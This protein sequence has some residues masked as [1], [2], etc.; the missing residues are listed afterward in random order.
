MIKLRNVVLSLAAGF[1]ATGALAQDGH[2]VQDSETTTVAHEMFGGDAVKLDFLAFD[3]DT[4]STMFEPKAKLIFGGSATIDPGTEFSVT[5]TL[6]NAT[7]A[8]SVSYRDFMWGSWSPLA[9]TDDTDTTDVNEECTMN[10]T[11]LT[12]AQLANEV[13]VE[14]DGGTRGSD[15]VTFDVTII[16]SLDGDGNVPSPATAISGLATPALADSAACDHDGDATTSDVVYQRYTQTTRKIVFVLPAVNA[17]GLTANTSTTGDNSVDVVVTTKI[18]Q[19]K[20]TG[21][22]IM[23]SVSMGHMCGDREVA[24]APGTAGCPV[25]E[26]VKVI[27]G[28]TSTGGSGMIS[29]DPEDG[30]AVLVGGDG[31]ALD[32]QR[33]TLATVEVSA[34]SGSGAR[35]PTDGTLIT[36]FTDD[37]AGTLAITVMSDSF[38]E[39]DIVYIDDNSNDKVDGREAFEMSGNSAT[40][41]VPLEDGSM[42]IYYVPNGEDPLKHR[43]M[44]STVAATEFSNVDNRTVSSKAGKAE[45]GLHGIKIIAARAYAIAPPTSNDTTNVRVTCESANEDGCNVFLDCNDQMGMNSF[46]EA[47]AMVGPGSTIR[48]DQDDIADALMVDGWEGRLACD[49]LSSDEIAVQVLTR[50]DG[51]LVNNT[52]INS[53]G[54]NPPA[55]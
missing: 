22:S 55:N 52:A 10:N 28:I 25:V 19:T 39:D 26:A 14:R 20:S 32:P 13:E 43:T 38:R 21:T 37:L 49:V 48:W 27:T 31:K 36:D 34:N 18:E 41:T 40:D 23:E 12:F 51:V 47:G 15:S 9:V 5:Y 4:P 11:T 3:A 1:L 42:T 16:S 44:F 45:L 50:S 8:D 33:I 35:S 2:F 24:K 30:R 46:G 17:S 6:S 53:G 54:T 7:F 29:L